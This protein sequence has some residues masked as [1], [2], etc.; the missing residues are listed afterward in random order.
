MV[1]ARVGARVVGARDGARIGA[2]V[3]DA[4]SRMESAWVEYSRVAVTG[5]VP[6]G[7]L[8]S[9]CGALWS[10]GGLWNGEHHDRL[11]VRA[12]GLLHH[13][14]LVQPGLGT[15]V[16]IVRQLLLPLVLRV[17]V[18]YWSGSVYRE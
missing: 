14:R 12:L 10:P 6:P 17:G 7:E 18:V 1:G 11:R 16:G 4:W 5:V 13:P 15:W 2:R 9:V 3:V 8:C